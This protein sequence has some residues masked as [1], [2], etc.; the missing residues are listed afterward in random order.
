MMCADQIEGLHCQLP[1][2]GLRYWRRCQIKSTEDK[3]RG[4]VT[5]SCRSE[6]M[7][8]IHFIFVLFFSPL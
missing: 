3:I 4:S 6:V 1:L 8:S 5:F 7:A 2:E